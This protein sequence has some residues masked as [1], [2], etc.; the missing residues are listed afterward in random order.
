MFSTLDRLIEVPGGKIFSRTWSSDKKSNSPIILLHDSLGSIDLWGSFPLTIAETT[1]R[2]VVAYDRLGFGRSTARQEL[3]SIRFISEEAEIYFPAIKS[4]LEIKHFTLFG[5]SVGG[6][7]AV[8][9]AAHFQNECDAVITESAQAFVED[10]TIKGIQIAKQKFKNPEAVEKLKKLHGEKA[11]WVLNA[12]ID[13]WL[14]PEFSSWS[15]KDT[16]PKL[17]C[18]LLAI[19]GDKDDYGSK[20]FPEMISGLAGGKSQMQLIAD[21]GH[22]P[23]REKKEQV[24]HLVNSFLNLKLD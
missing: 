24:L 3:P 21:C 12:W 7:M 16:L 5:H 18:P 10:L 20:K 11:Q 23:H 1:K 2:T 9:I 13:V 17:K 6:A 15:L 4:E 8:S 14:S 19:H 22:V